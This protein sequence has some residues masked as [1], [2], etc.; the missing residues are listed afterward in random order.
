MMRQ[1]WP[2]ERLLSKHKANAIIVPSDHGLQPVPYGQLLGLVGM[3]GKEG[4]GRSPVGDD[5]A[6]AV[7]AHALNRVRGELSTPLVSVTD[8][9]P[10][11]NGLSL[12]VLVSTP[13]GQQQDITWSRGALTATVDQAKAASGPAE[14]ALL[15]QASSEASQR[16]DGSR[17]DH[18]MTASHAATALF[19][20]AGAV[21]DLTAFDLMTLRAFSESRPQGAVAPR[22]VRPARARVDRVAPVDYAVRR[23]TRSCRAD[24]AGAGWFRRN[25]HAG[26]RGR[27]PRARLRRGHRLG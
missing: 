14:A 20:M 5:C 3:A 18:A 23:R 1:L 21:D 25:A 10:F 11:R 12:G 17:R 15:A 8:V 13:A 26:L 27:Y 7:R 6:A 2:G 4:P 24:L 19:D 9:Q 22:A 16:L